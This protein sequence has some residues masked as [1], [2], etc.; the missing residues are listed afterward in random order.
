M[1][2]IPSFWKVLCCH[3][4]R[5]VFIF[6]WLNKR[7]TLVSDHCK[8]LDAFL[9]LIYNSGTDLGGGCRGCAPLPHLSW[10][11]FYFLFAL[12]ICLRPVTSQL[13][14]SLVVHPLLKKFLDP[15]LQSD[16]YMQ[17]SF[18]FSLQ[19]TDFPFLLSLWSSTL[20]SISLK[21]S[22]Q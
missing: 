7:K 4:K 21:A 8:H 20:L 10:P 17:K 12:K 13:H 16:T 3:I 5:V 18:F 1:L 6:L 19:L 15:P 22:L 11:A 9:N 2:V 14:H